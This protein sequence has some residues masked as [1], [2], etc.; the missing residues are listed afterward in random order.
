V[1]DHAA[2]A[3][4]RREAGLSIREHHQAIAQALI[5]LGHQTRPGRLAELS[6]ILGR[7]VGAFAELTDN[8]AAEIMT[9]LI[10]ALE[11]L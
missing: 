4:E 5:V 1:T 10:A 11:A 9:A 8:D 3:A 2:N 7:P 6:R